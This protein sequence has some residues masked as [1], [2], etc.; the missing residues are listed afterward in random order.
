M[1]HTFKTSHGRRTLTAA[2]L[3]R[4]AHAAAR[5]K[6]GVRIK[7]RFPNALIA[8]ARLCAEELGDGLG[9][10]VNGACRRYRGV[11]ADCVADSELTGLAT[12]EESEAITIR[13][14]EGMTAEEIR[15][16]VAVSVSRCEERRIPSTPQ[17]CERFY[18]EGF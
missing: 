5:E 13:A 1:S 9:E 2:E 3:I 18:V 17:P 15:S 4:K 10:W 8:K 16:A 14:P 6:A 12:R 7:V 11:S